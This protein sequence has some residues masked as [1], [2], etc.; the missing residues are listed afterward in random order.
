MNFYTD[1][2]AKMT[3]LSIRSVT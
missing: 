3:W 2:R 1:Y